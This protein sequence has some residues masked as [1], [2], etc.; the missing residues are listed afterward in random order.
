MDGRL[1]LVVGFAGAPAQILLNMGGG[2]FAEG[3]SLEP[4]KCALGVTGMAFADF[5]GDG[6]LDLL[7]SG[8]D[9]AGILVNACPRPSKNLGLRIR[10]PYKEAPGALVR[11]Y[12]AQDRSLGIRQVGV[13]NSTGCQDFREAH[14]AVAPGTY[15]AAVL[16][17]NG[18]VRQK[19]M[20]VDKKDLLWDIN[21]KDEPAAEPAAPAKEAPAKDAPAKEAGK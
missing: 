17:T 6:D 10:V 2:R 21:A 15:K 4:F 19:T 11:L 7:M 12:D 18:T 20:T 9:S 16:L 1:D 13:M 5:D 14:F 8:R 3:I